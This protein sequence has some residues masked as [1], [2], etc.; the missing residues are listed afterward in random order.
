MKTRFL[1][2]LIAMSAFAPA[3]TLAANVWA[4]G[5]N[6][7]GP[8]YGTNVPPGLTNVVAIAAGW[9]HG[10]AMTADGRVI[11]W[12][13]NTSGQLNVPANLTNVVAIAAGAFHSLA[14]KADGAIVAWGDN[15][16]GE[17][18]VPS[19]LTQVVAVSA[20]Y[21][22][23]F[24][25][26]ADGTVAAWGSNSAGI[27][28]VPPYVTN[29]VAVSGDAVFALALRADGTVA[30]WPSGCNYCNVPADLTNAIAVSA[31]AD[32]SLVLRANGTVEAWGD[33]SSGQ[34]NVPLDLTNVIA[35][36]ARAV[37]GGPI[38]LKADGTVVAWGQVQTMPPGLAGV[39]AIAAWGNYFALASVAPGK[40]V[41][42]FITPLSQTVGVGS[43]AFFSVSATGTG[44]LNYQWYFGTNQI[45]G[46]TNWW[47]SLNNV[48]TAQSGA[49]WVL[50]SNSVGSAMSQT[51]TLNVLPLLQINMVPAITLQGGVGSKYEIDYLNA[52]GPTNAWTALAT[53]ILTNAQ[54]FYFDVSA[55]GQPARFYRLVQVP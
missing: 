54:Q 42:S 41:I 18:N 26:K 51:V 49:Y 33:N 7:N 29:V 21:G 11:A 24:A 16:Y 36:T 37:Y 4:W 9:E 47:L 44:P 38:A 8:A 34:T 35:V 23:S 32:Y 28:N 10:L 6:P 15:T 27:P 53:V 25:V 52:V 50:V 46:A 55:I 14:L 5:Y 45:F 43:Q 3:K 2:S 48:Q 22:I 20:G 17:C 30:S 1:L 19:Q 31:G 39:S 40:P 13:D 12:G